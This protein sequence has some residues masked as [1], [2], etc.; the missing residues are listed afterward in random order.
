MQEIDLYGRKGIYVPYTEQELNENTIAEILRDNLKYHY[1]NFKAIS[2][3]QLYERGRQDILDKV[4]LVRPQINNKIVENNAHHVT[5]F[6]IG[7]VFGDPI[8]YVNRT[9]T[10]KA[11]LDEL[12]RYMLNNDKPSK[13]KDLAEDW[14]IS[15]QGYR[16]VMPYDDEDKP[17]VIENIDPKLSFVVYSTDIGNKELFG[18]YM[19]KRKDDTYELKVYTK[20]YVYTYISDFDENMQKKDYVVELLSKEV[21]PLNDIPIVEYRLNKN[22]LGLVELVKTMTDALNQITSSDIDD[23][24]Q[25]VQS[26]LVFINQEVD[27]KTLIELLEVGAIQIM[28]NDPARPANVNLLS[29]KLSHSETRILYDR[30]YNNMLTICGVPRMTDKASSGDTGQARLIGEGWSMADERA[31]Q[32]ELSFK[33]SDKKVVD[34][35]LKICKSKPQKTK[36]RNL[37]TSDIEIKFTRNRSDNMMTKSQTLLNLKQANVEPTIAFTIAGL[38]SDPNEAVKASLAY[39]GDDFWKAE[40]VETAEPSEVF[41]TE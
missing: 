39:F 20:P 30:I 11:E 1:K 19:S 34:L 27:K 15:G 23:I 6:K 8:Q 17:F 37:K 3:L 12:N 24:E 36:I 40:V 28:S 5:Q 9:D 35:A 31:K 14:Y 4:K 29:Q 18:T 13:D 16:W 41:D 32:D 7:Y 21:N 38:F 25:F 26:L 22:R 10:Q 2:Y 33:L